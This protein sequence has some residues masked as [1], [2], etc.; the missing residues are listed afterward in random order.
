MIFD[1][2]EWDVHFQALYGELP[3]TNP[4]K[5]ELIVLAA[6]RD[7]HSCWFLDLAESGQIVPDELEQ[8]T[9]AALWLCLELHRSHEPAKR[10]GDWIKALKPKERGG[11]VRY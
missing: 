11:A 8:D 10:L 6:G 9:D 3:Q 7:R 2:M 5:V 1:S 4:S